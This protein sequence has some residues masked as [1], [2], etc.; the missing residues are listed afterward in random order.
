VN[1]DAVGNP[2]TLHRR[3]I[4]SNQNPDLSET[5]RQALASIAQYKQ[6]AA[7][8][9][10]KLGPVL[11]AELQK[12]GVATVYAEYDGCGDSGCF[13]AISCRSAAGESLEES[14]SEQLRQHVE[15]YLYDLLEVRHGGWENNDG[16]F[17]VFSWDVVGDQLSQAHSTRYTETSTESY[18]NLD[19]IAARTGGGS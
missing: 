1:D 16:A 13:E 18:P 14:L 5:F 3:S 17:G 4:M 12:A 15:T 2:P 6:E 11:R 19:D 8:R 10:T 7:R 9:I